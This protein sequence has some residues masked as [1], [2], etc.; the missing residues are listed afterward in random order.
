MVGAVGSDQYMHARMRAIGKTPAQCDSLVRL[1][2]SD[3]VLSDANLS[4][5][6]RRAIIEAHQ[7]TWYQ[8]SPCPE[9]FQA[10]TGVRPGDPF[11]DVLWC[12]LVGKV[13]HEVHL[14]LVAEGL[15][16]ELLRDGGCHPLQAPV[17]AD[18]RVVLREV[19]FVDDAAYPLKADSVEGLIEATSSTA[20]VVTK[21]YARFG[22]QLSYEPNKTAAMLTV[23]W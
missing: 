14:G 1:I 10:R 20:A 17:N 15:A 9:Y 13:A 8:C 18:S 6:L 7:S 3:P 4:G 23:F 22:L 19:S 16:P 12:L 2:K 21:V 11:A 5:N